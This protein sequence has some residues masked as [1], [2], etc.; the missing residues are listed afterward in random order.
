[1]RGRREVRRG[2]WGATARLVLEGEGAGVREE[3]GHEER[4]EGYICLTCRSCEGGG[5]VRVQR[6]GVVAVFLWGGVWMDT[7]I[8]IV[9]GI[10]NPRLGNIVS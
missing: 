6:R 3:D 10:S 7:G 9:I 4:E 5:G 1:M 8:G 2:R